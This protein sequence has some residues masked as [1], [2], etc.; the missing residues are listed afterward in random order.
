MRGEPDTKVKLKI[1]RPKPQAIKEIE[2]VRAVIKVESVKGAVI[3]EDKIGY[4]RITQFSEPTA[5]AL[6]K[7]LEKLLAA[8]MTALILDLR[9]NPGGL[10]S[11]SVEVSQKF[12][13]NGSLIVSTRGRKG[14]GE[15]A[16]YVAKGRSHYTDFPMVVLVNG[17]S[18]SASEIT[19]GALQDHHRAIIIGEKTFGKGSVQS[20]LPLEDGSAIRLT[21]AKY[22][23][24]SGRTIHEI[25]VEPDIVVSLAPDQWRR[26]IL[27]RSRDEIGDVD[28]EDAAKP[29]A[30]PAVDTQ[31]ERAKDVL[32]AIRLFQAQQRSA[33]YAQ[34]N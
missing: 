6:Q 20:V 21:T 26:V 3:L 14:G 8:G 10:L 32:K 28:E 34:K 24:P 23:T 25:G 1:I 19:A 7:A 22:Y 17:G 2:L 29:A 30:E 4:V 9:G 5:E 13:K 27:K 11:S 18:A 16:Q 12:I 15:Q 33:H 31:L